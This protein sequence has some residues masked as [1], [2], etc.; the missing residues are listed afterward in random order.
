MEM[1]WEENELVKCKEF[2]VFKENWKKSRDIKKEA[3]KV[4]NSRLY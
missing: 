2:L 4:K 1:V 3:K